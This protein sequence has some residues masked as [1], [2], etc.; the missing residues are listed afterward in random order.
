MFLSFFFWNFL[1]YIENNHVFTLFHSVFHESLPWVPEVF[2]ACSGI[3][4]R[5]R[6]NAEATIEGWTRDLYVTEIENRER[7]VSG[8]QGNISL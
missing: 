1:V 5:C 7:K 3:N 8:T 2:L 6:P 4:L